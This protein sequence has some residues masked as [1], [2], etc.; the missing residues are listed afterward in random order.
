[1]RVLLVGNG[2][3]E[4]AMATAMARS[5]LVHRL[6]ATRPNAGIRRHAE[7]VD[8]AP[9]D[10][11]GLLR[12][13]DDEGIQLVV[14]GPEAP[15]VMGV[16]DAIRAINV[17]VFG[18]G[19]SGARLEGSK[20]FAKAFLTRHAIPT[21]AWAA[22]DDPAAAHAHLDQRGGPWVI[23]ADGLAGGKGVVI[24][25]S[26]GDAHAAVDD[27]MVVDQLGPAGRRVVIEDHLS[28]IEV[29]AMALIDGGALVPLP[30]AHDHKRL[31]DGNR[32][33]NT[34]GMGACS[35][36]HVV[37]DEVEEEIVERILKPTAR[38]LRREGIT[39]RGVIYAGL[40]VT[41]FG[42]RVLEYN[43]RLGDPEAQVLLARLDCDF[44]A[45]CLATAEGRLRDAEIAFRRD[46]ALT[47]VMASA[48]YPSGMRTGD[49]LDG[50]E[51]A[52][53]VPGVVVHQAGTA[54]H[55][56]KIVTAGGRVLS[57]TAT[58]SSLG[59]ARQRAYEGVARIRFSGAHY[60]TD[61]GK[62]LP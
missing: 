36:S 50:I 21:A 31:L 37:S 10:T 3:R 6:Y 8:V 22:F 2:G 32:G 48:G 15:L 27:M 7:A 42:P 56:G 51:D 59:E 29:S 9:T 40:M 4:H 35:P 45:L 57:V 28:G 38:A 26:L 33:P 13:V 30:V 12:V 19:E 47:V 34:G 58:G 5:P 43:V 49:E 46:A 1:M 60:R 39:Y 23:K 20:S 44:A 17:P 24:A 25:E 16:A 61:I 41:Q 11:E 18:P 54:I 53:R 55:H 14:I 52:E 62:A